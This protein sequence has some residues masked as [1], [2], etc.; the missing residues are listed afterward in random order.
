MTGQP[1]RPEPGRDSKSDLLQ[2]AQ[3]AVKDR[4]E[5]AVAAAAAANTPAGRKRRL[6]TLAV[7]GVI[8]AVLLI[9][10]PEWLVG[11]AAP[12]P[13][14]PAVATASLRLTLL[15][16]RDRVFA[17]QKRFGRLPATLGDAGVLTPGIAFQR[18][19]SAEFTLQARLGDSLLVLSAADSG[20][21]F[22]GR[23]LQIIRR[24]GRP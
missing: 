7:L 1:P 3:A 14:T 22:L 5:A 23:S 2:A 18:A 13:E 15:R 9:I 4:G 20:A 21:A 17:F 16:E 12:P 8:G 11:P 24:R 6:G 19:G 10:Q